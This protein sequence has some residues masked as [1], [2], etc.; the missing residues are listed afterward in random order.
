MQVSK[1]FHLKVSCKSQGA[2][3][4]SF[5]SCFKKL[6]FVFYGLLK[7]REGQTVLDL[8]PE[9]INIRSLDFVKLKLF[10][11]NIGHYAATS[12]YVN[13]RVSFNFGQVLAHRMRLP[14]LMTN[15]WPNMMSLSILCK[16]NN[17]CEFN[18]NCI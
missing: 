14:P 6:L 16:I 7:M 18:D 11:K 4:Q 2:H 3:S 13:V 9:L 17:R 1:K 8:D 12:T 10:F 5:P 15:S